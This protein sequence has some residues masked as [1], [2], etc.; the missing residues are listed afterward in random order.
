SVR[1]SS[2]SPRARRRRSGG[3]SLVG[4]AFDEGVVGLLVEKLGI[5]L[6]GPKLDDPTL[7]VWILVDVFGVVLELLVDLSPLATNRAVE[8]GGRLHR[9][10]HPEASPR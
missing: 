7:A 2:A 4:L 3:R 8:V 10:H 1:A 6:D 9:F 5:V